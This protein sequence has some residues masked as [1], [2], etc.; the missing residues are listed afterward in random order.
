MR[1]ARKTQENSIS[2][3]LPIS[4]WNDPLLDPMVVSPSWRNMLHI[5][6]YKSKN[7]SPKNKKDL[8]M[9]CHTPPLKKAKKQGEMPLPNLGP[10]HLNM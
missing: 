4:G 5:Y 2:S 8:G 10:V 3:C 6:I 7:F 1:Y 9:A